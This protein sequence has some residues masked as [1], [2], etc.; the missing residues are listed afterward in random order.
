LD[1]YKTETIPEV[2]G[3][4]KKQFQKLWTCIKKK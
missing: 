2:L 1:L 4:Y 3:L